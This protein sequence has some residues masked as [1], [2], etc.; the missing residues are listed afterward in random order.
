MI[1]AFNRV[2]AILALLVVI[3]CSALSAVGVV[4][5]FLW[6]P[7]RDRWV[8]IIETLLRIPDTL[9]LAQR[10][11]LVGSA[12]IVAL[13]AFILLILELRPPQ[14]EDNVR[15]KGSDGSETIIARG[16]ISQRV[17]YAVDRLDDVVQVAPTV[18][19]KGEGLTV[20]LHVLTTPFIDVP[21][22][23]EEIRAV[24]R[25]VIEKQMGLVLKKVTVRIDHE[26]FREVTSARDDG[27]LEGV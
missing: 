12:V 10:S 26:A 5:P 15:V 8:L 3:V 6:R 19:G 4:L 1:N 2:G 17:Q 13:V 21:L 11:L 20:H 7:F 16:A 24:A 25:E 14:R 22:K 23:T 27:S 18:T 9:T